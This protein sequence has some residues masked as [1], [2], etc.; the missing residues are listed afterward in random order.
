M[1]ILYNDVTLIKNKYAYVSNNKTMNNTRLYWYEM[2]INAI[3]VTETKVYEIENADFYKTLPASGFFIVMPQDGT[4]E[5]NMFFYYYNYITNSVE[6]WQ[7]FGIIPY[8]GALQD[9][10]VIPYQQ[11]Y[12]T[13]NLGVSTNIPIFDDMDDAESWIA[14]GFT[15]ASKIKNVDESYVCDDLLLRRLMIPN[16][17]LQIY[18]NYGVKLSKNIGDTLWYTDNFSNYCINRTTDEPVIF[19]MIDYENG[20]LYKGRNPLVLSASPDFT[21][22]SDGGLDPQLTKFSDSLYTVLGHE[23]YAY[24][25]I[26][27]TSSNYQFGARAKC[28]VCGDNMSGDFDSNYLNPLMIINPALTDITLYPTA[29]VAIDY[30]LF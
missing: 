26:I 11:T 3:G 1:S 5:Q 16:W 22:N 15:D 24:Y 18:S 25:S 27:D 10:Y 23:Y 7:P 19:A 8:E 29:R 13:K 6:L 12:T 14:S 4:T 20:L 2:Y 28:K 17:N 21:Y 30:L 9:V